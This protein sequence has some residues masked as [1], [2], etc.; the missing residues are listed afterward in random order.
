MSNSR[1]HFRDLHFPFN[2]SWNS[3][4][5]QRNCCTLTLRRIIIQTSC[6][7][8]AKSMLLL[9]YY[10]WQSFVF[11]RKKYKFRC[12]C[13]NLWHARHILWQAAV[14]F[15]EQIQMQRVLFEKTSSFTGSC[16]HS[17]N[18]DW[19]ILRTNGIYDFFWKERCSYLWYG[20]LS[21]LVSKFS[22]LLILKWWGVIFQWLEGREC[23][24]NLNQF[25]EKKE[26]GKTRFWGG[27]QVSRSCVI[28]CAQ[29]EP[30]SSSEMCY[31]NLNTRK[32]HYIRN[33]IIFWRPLILL[34]NL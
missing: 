14:L 11:V 25:E 13:A 32:Q 2:K 12:G 34:Q 27:A 6:L 3:A 1:A 5:K 23:W 33:G 24:C 7:Y 15:R 16:G 4:P 21:S 8:F 18:S 30:N 10:R 9:S 19:V 17:G 22:R 20:N 29:R 28:K 26:P 31:S